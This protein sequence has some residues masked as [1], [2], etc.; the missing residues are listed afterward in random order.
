MSSETPVNMVCFQQ[1]PAGQHTDGYSS[2]C[3]IGKD[4]FWKFLRGVGG[5]EEAD[6]QGALL[7]DEPTLW[8]AQSDYYWTQLLPIFHYY[9]V[10]AGYQTVCKGLTKVLYQH[11]E[12][13]CFHNP[14]A[15]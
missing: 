14:F 10:G 2:L 12:P 11:F 6:S 15:K 5:E 3:V 8:Q 4:F 7:T 1:Q 13:S 9:S